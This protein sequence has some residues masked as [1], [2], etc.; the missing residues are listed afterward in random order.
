MDSV[1]T[2]S[3][4]ILNIQNWKATNKAGLWKLLEEAKTHSWILVPT[5]YEDR[6]YSFSIG[7]MGSCWTTHGKMLYICCRPGKKYSMGSCEDVGDMITYS[8]LWQL[9]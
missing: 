6:L 4:M 7:K 5:R 3:R 1:A 8:L 2:G 9:L